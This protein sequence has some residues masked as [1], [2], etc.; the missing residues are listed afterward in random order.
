MAIVSDRSAPVVFAGTVKETVPFPLPLEP[1]VIF[2]HCAAV[3]AVHVHPAGAVTVT[4][5][6]API[7]GTLTLVALKEYEQLG[8]AAAWLMVNVRPAAATVPTRAE[9]RFG[10]TR[11]R[12]VPLPLPLA[13]EVMVIH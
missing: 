12:T 5:R 3:T 7:I 1:E 13:P 8:I 4:E 9:P 10:T 2:I 6:S 11:Y